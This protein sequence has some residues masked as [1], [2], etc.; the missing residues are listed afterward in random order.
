MSSKSQSRSAFRK[1]N[2][3]L[4]QR[5]KESYTVDELNQLIALL[6]QH[7]TLTLRR[8]RSGGASAVTILDADSLESA[9]GD[10]LQF[11]WTRDS[12]IQALAENLILTDPELMRATRVS[13]DQWRRGLL[14]NLK[15]YELNQGDFVNIIDGRVSGRH[16][17]AS[18]HP[19]I[20]FNAQSLKGLPW[21]WSHKQ[22][23]AHG[24]LN[25]LLFWQLNAGSISLADPSVNTV[26]APYATLLHHVFDKVNVWT[27]ED[28]GAWEDIPAIHFS[29]ILC[30]AV[31]LAE[32]LDFVRK[33]GSVHFYAFGRDWEVSEKRIERLLNSCLE[34][35][36]E[37]GTNESL[38]PFT[39]SV[40]L[41][42][43]NG[44]L[45]QALSGRQLIDDA[46]V[47]RIIQ[48]L[49][50]ELMGECGIGRY[51]GD[52]WDGRERRLEF[53]SD[54]DEME[55]CHGSATLAFILGERYLRTGDEHYLDWAIYHLNRTLGSIT[56]EWVLPEAYC[57]DKVSKQ[58]EPDENRPLAWTQ[59]VTAM[60]LAMIKRCAA[61]KAS[62]ETPPRGAHTHCSNEICDIS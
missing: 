38:H 4:A 1:N 54:R 19:A 37:L 61:K 25:F 9:L 40:D 2:P 28:F 5:L 16:E 32:Q 50:N 48:N 36:K 6:E 49:E 53:E 56:K 47:D 11:M 39:R 43:L 27:D 45:L 62:L 52:V 31:S 51:K 12:V 35:L 14:Y 3:D 24:F 21:P 30:V 10:N 23:D 42:Q 34:K 15:F 22:N 58:W 8:Y 33:A 18:A 26:A 20:R 7:S 60:A 41:A 46:T 55:W 44:L 59:S 29:S 13:P 57:I 17:A